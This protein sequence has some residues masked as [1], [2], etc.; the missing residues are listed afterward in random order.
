M[1][2]TRKILFSIVCMLCFLLLI[3]CTSKDAPN[4]DKSE[5]VQTIEFTE[6]EKVEIINRYA[7]KVSEKFKGTNGFKVGFVKYEDGTCEFVAFSSGN[8]SNS[9][10]PNLNKYQS[11][12]ECFDFLMESNYID[13]DGTILI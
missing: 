9:E 6:E 5:S 2:R 11:V 7:A 12:S 10:K 3:G 1:K 8:N 13:K 4:H